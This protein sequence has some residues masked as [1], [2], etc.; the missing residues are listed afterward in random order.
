[1][2]PERTA[3]LIWII[4][5]VAT[6]IVGITGM[7]LVWRDMRRNNSVDKLIATE[8]SQCD[9]RNAERIE[10]LLTAQSSFGKTF[11]EL[12]PLVG[13]LKGHLMTLDVDS[14]QQSRDTGKLPQQ[15]ELMVNLYSSLNVRLAT[16]PATC[17]TPSVIADEDIAAIAQPIAKLGEMLAKFDELNSMPTTSV[18]IAREAITHVHD[19]LDG[20]ITVLQKQRKAGHQ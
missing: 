17:D 3:L 20:I 12:L 10:W 15:T 1:M 14:A 16:L 13:S 2:T 5:T 7:V 11:L 9:K 18:W 19:A 6:V 8:I 4:S